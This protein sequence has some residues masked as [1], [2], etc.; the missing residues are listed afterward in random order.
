MELHFTM[1]RICMSGESYKQYLFLL[2]EL[3]R[4]L[5]KQEIQYAKHTH[6]HTHRIDEVE[7]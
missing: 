5:Y 6:S 1:N 2:L 4:V 7:M 3:A